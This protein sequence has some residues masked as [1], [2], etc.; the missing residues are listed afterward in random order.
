MSK[1]TFLKTIFPAQD[2]N[3]E[4]SLPPIAEV[5]FTT[6]YSTAQVDE[7]DDIWGGYGRVPGTFPYRMQDMYTRELHDR[8]FLTPVLENEYLKATFMPDFGG[9]LWSLIDKTT[10]KELLVANPVV[11]PCNLANRN[12]WTAGGVEWNCGIAGHHAHTCS[13]IYTAKTQLEDGTPVL[14]MYEYERIRQVV[15]QM[16]FFLP[17]GSKLLYARMRIMNNKPYSV[18]IY[19]WS[20]IAV[21]EEEGTRIIAPV[22]ETYSHLEGS[23]RKTTVPRNKYFSMDIT[24]PT[25]LKYSVDFFWRIPVEERKYMCSL[26]KNGYGL[27]QTSTSRLRGRKLFAWGHGQG[28]R[29]WQKYLTADDCDGR[30]VEIQAGLAQTQ[31]ESLPMPPRSAW[32][33]LE[34]YGPMQA[35][36]AK[37]HGEWEDAKVES[38]DRLNDLISAKRL[39]EMLVETKAMAKSPAEIV[40]YSEDRWGALEVLRREAKDERPLCPYLDFGTTDERHEQWIEL[41]ENGTF[42]EHDPLEVPPSWMLSQ[43]WMPLIENAIKNSDK[44]NWY[45]YLQYGMTLYAL[46]RFEEAEQYL[47]KSYMLTPSPWAMYGL[48]M[49]ARLNKNNEKSANLAIKASKMKPDDISLAKEAARVLRRTNE[50]KRMYKFISELPEEIRQIPRIKLYYAMAHFKIGDVEGAEKLLYE[51]GGIL[52]ADI[53]E[54]EVTLSD[55]WYSLEEEK[56]KRRGEVFDREA[57]VLPEMFDFRMSAEQHS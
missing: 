18:P 34:A 30:Y 45:A 21:P 8:E 52:V 46:Q 19:W 13:R 55:L 2:M 12:A 40:E 24:Y 28:G 20:N 3:G 51:N 10:G 38:A 14:R 7:D 22:T 16:D 57:A 37:I 35:D 5:T 9:K 15:Y 17:D 53:Q 48:A 43:E 44:Y 33:W 11:R 26:D 54:G 49:L 36:P 31:S 50:W 56:A 23:L 42:G 4:S 32:E 41:L 25:E 29:R 39:E 6:G 47:E 27:V 1:L